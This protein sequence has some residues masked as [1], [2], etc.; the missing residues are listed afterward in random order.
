MN[1]SYMEKFYQATLDLKQ[2]L[3]SD[4]SLDELEHLRLQNHLT[5][6]H[7]AFIEWKQRNGRPSYLSTLREHALNGAEHNSLS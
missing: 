1:T 4:C 5:A 2:E 3:E 7:I 6:I